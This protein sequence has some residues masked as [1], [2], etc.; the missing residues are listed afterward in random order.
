MDQTPVYF[1][2]HPNKTIELCKKTITLHSSIDDTRRCTVAVT[3]T[4][5]GLK[6][7]LLVVFKRKMSAKIA[8]KRT[9][10]VQERTSFCL[11]RQCMDE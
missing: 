5:S 10:N 3:I 11:P 6:L 7:P 8:K 1:S 4:A 2:M 9:L